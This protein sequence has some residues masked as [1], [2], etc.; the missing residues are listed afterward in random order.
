M[1]VN[2]YSVGGLGNAMAGG[3]DR[4]NQP[5]GFTMQTADGTSRSPPSRIVHNQPRGPGDFPPT[6]MEQ[7]SGFTRYQGSSSSG[8]S[9]MMM[10]LIAVIGV[11]VVGGLIYMGVSHSK[12][13]REFLASLTPAQKLEYKKE[14]EKT[15]RQRML[16]DSI[17]SALGGGLD[18]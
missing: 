4:H 17:G 13:E 3:W 1:D 7:P 8:G 9:G 6:P 5:S 18:F 10:P 11:A 14:Q 2:Y 15:Y 12:R 16:T